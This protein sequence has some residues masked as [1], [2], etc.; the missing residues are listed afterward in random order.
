MRERERKKETFLVNE[1]GKKLISDS[2]EKSH[3]LFSHTIKMAL[4]KRIDRNN[5]NLNQ[6]TCQHQQEV[7]NAIEINVSMTF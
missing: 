3:T 1:D 6:F 7:V 4:S 5:L 2:R